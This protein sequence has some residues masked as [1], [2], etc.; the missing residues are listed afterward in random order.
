MSNATN[1]ALA[2]AERAVLLLGVN[3]C[4][5]P[6]EYD[7]SPEDGG[8]PCSHCGEY[9]VCPEGCSLAEVARDGAHDRGE[10]CSVW[11]CTATM[12]CVERSRAVGS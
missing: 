9:V 5:L 12:A 10:P 11:F 6:G 4:R 8:E 2:E 7:E 3:G 1:K